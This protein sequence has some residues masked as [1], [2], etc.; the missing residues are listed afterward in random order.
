MSL[1]SAILITAGS[2]PA[3]QGTAFVAGGMV[4]ASGTAQ[5]IGAVAVSLLGITLRAF[6]AEEL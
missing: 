4:L 2:I 1:V 3:I 6:R 5:G